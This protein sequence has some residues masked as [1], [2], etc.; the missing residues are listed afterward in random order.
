MALFKEGE[1]EA[2]WLQAVKNKEERAQ[3]PHCRPAILSWLRARVR[4]LK[5]ILCATSLSSMPG[6]S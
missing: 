6:P 3:L 4:N 5:F 1:D 2:Q